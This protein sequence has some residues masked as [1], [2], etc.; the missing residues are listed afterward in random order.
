M[1]SELFSRRQLTEILK[2][3]LYGLLFLFAMLLQAIVLPRLT[4]G[5][6]ALC[7]VPTC[8]VCVAVQ[9]G[10]DR[11]TLYGLLCGAL[12]CLSGVDCGPLYI[13]SLTLS[14]AIA[15]AACDRFYTRT[16]VPALVL[17]LLGL[18]LCEGLAFLFRVY[19]GSVAAGLFQ[20]VLLPEILFSILVYPLFFLGT[21][22]V[23]RIGR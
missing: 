11:A 14:A 22:A 21:W 9:E 4:I 2:W 15:G 18:T 8:V 13:V 16:F 6:I 10:A 12:F 1:F 3:T 19:V 17:S 5:G 20:T 7:T 23:S